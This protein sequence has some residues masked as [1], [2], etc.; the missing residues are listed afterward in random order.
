MRAI[1]LPSRLIILLASKQAYSY[2]RFYIGIDITPS[3]QKVVIRDCSFLL[4]SSR[5]RTGTDKSTITRF[6]TG[7]K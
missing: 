3:L 2:F 5:E 6:C 4:K 7:G 1:K